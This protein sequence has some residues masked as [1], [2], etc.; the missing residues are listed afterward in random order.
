MATTKKNRTKQA[1]LF[2]IYA[3]L[4]PAAKLPGN[5][6]T[7]YLAANAMNGLVASRQADMQSSA[8]AL[9]SEV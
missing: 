1:R 2:E 5:R 3:T 6:E 4:L 8:C 7:Y 9:I